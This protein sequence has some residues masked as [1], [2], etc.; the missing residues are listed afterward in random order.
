MYITSKSI[1]SLFKFSLTDK[2]LYQMQDTDTANICMCAI[3]FLTVCVCVSVK[4]CLAC[5][6]LAG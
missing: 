2:I 1:E 6:W 5:G 3:M 4:V